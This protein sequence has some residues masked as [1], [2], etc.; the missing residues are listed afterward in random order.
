MKQLLII[1]LIF[2]LKTQ[3]QILLNDGKMYHDVLFTT[4]TYIYFNLND[5][6]YKV[7]LENVKNINGKFPAYPDTNYYDDM[8]KAHGQ[9]QTGFSLMI[10]GIGIA[11]LGSLLTKDTEPLIPVTLT[12]I[13]GIFSIAGIFTEISAFGKARQADNKQ[14]AIEYGI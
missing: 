10:V 4:P 3:A 12:V 6:M 11:G 14:R 7:S 2:S 9:A 1:I 5:T 13:G 8:Y